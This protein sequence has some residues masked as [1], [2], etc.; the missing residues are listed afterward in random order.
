MPLVYVLIDLDRAVWAVYSDFERAQAALKKLGPEH[1]RL[2]T[3]EVDRNPDF[4]H[5]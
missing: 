1:Y 3:W 2:E 4:D 5:M